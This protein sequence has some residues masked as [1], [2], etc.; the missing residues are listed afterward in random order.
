MT[1]PNEH[2]HGESVSTP[3]EGGALSPRQ[4]AFHRADG[5]A[6]N[7]WLLRS[8]IWDRTMALKPV[9]VT[10]I[11]AVKAFDSVSHE[12]MIPATK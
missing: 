7:V 1:Y 4:N 11:D 10:F 3:G 9:F 2:D 5:L 8:V 12:T 6:D